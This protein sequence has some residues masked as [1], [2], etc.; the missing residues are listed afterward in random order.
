MRLHDSVVSTYASDSRLSAKG[1]ALSRLQTSRD[2]ADIVKKFKIENCRDYFSLQTLPVPED[3]I[4]D[5]FSEACV[6]CSDLRF[7]C[8][9]SV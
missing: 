2:M 5:Y 7:H 9:K 1:N 4:P 6:L 8:A 3:I